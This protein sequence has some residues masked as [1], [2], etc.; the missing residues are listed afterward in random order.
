[1]SLAGLRTKIGHTVRISWKDSL[2]LKQTHVGKKQTLEGKLADCMPAQSMRKGTPERSPHQI[3]VLFINLPAWLR[4]A[5][6]KTSF[7]VLHCDNCEFAKNNDTVYRYAAV[8]N[9]DCIEKIDTISKK[10]TRLSLK[11]RNSARRVVK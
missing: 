9:S 7:G 11:K 5:I 8:L 2:I 3:R 1:M 10:S 6:R 4:E